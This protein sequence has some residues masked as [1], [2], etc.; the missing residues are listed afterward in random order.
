MLVAKEFWTVFHILA[1]LHLTQKN[2]G[3]SEVVACDI[4]AHAIDNIK[5]NALLNGFEITTKCADV[6][7]YLRE[8]NFNKE[9]FDVIILDPPAFTKKQRPSR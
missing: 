1:V 5:A 4:S 2:Y 7:D 3:A 6:F 8:L 9:K